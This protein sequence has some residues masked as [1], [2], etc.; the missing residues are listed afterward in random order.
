VKK[1]SVIVFMVSMSLVFLFPCEGKCQ[2]KKN[3]Y[4]MMSDAKEVKVYVAEVIDSS[5]QAADIRV[6]L[7]KSIEDA[8]ATRMTINFVPV[9]SENNADVVIT[10]DIIERIWMKEDPLDQIHGIGPAAM[11][12]AMSENYARMRAVFA[13]ERGGK[14]V[15]LKGLRRFFRRSNVIWKQELQATITKKVM[16]EKE[17]IPLLEDRIVQV[18]MRKCFSKNAQSLSTV[19]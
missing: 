19:Y 10:C 8:L 4:S 3:L 18:F 7:R 12:I 13:V 16:P 14:K 5:G 17:S 9:S 15:I 1:I 6:S 2:V 11:D